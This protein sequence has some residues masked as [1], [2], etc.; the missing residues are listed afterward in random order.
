MMLTFTLYC[1]S[2]SYV[3]RKIHINPEAV[4]AVVEGERRPRDSGSQKVATIRLLDGTEYC[5]QDSSRSV[6]Y[7]I[8][9]AKE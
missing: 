6:A 2:Y 8:M 4:A 9:A 3:D 7:Q 1:D 5:V